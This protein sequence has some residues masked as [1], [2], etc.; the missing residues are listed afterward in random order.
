MNSWNYGAAALAVLLVAPTAH[1]QDV[2]RSPNYG[3][4]RLDSGFVPDPHTVSVTAG[5]PNDA[6]RKSSGCAGYV[7]SAPDYRLHF[8]AGSLPLIISAE[9]SEDTTLVINGPDGDWYCDDDG[10]GRLDPIVRFNNPDSGQYD[11]WIGSYDESERPAATL[12]ITELEENATAGPPDYNATPNY[13]V[14]DLASGFTPDPHQINMRAGGERAASAMGSGCTGFITNAPDVRL[15]FDAGGLP[16]VISAA[17]QADTTLVINAPD[18]Q[19]YC[20]DDSGGGSDPRVRFA[21]PRSGRYEIWVGT[22]SS[23]DT[24]SAT[25][26]ISERDRVK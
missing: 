19:W 16:L 1:A 18:G 6:S 7:S 24:Q 15:V 14:V 10:S 13:G 26:R 22:Y 4:A 23:G 17:S 20:D 11:I 9:S 12:S 5:G 21:S 2:S 3:T 8:D 25:L